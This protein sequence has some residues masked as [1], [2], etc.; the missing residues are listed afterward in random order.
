MEVLPLLLIQP[1][2]M[3]VIYT[4]RVLRVPNNHSINTG[5]GINQTV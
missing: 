3:A 2:C 5:E 1:L 4:A